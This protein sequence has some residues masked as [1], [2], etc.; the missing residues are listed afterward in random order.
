M[1][2]SNVMKGIGNVAGSLL[3]IGA[4]LFGQAKAAEQSAKNVQDTIAHQKEM[5]QYAYGKDLEMWERQN[6]YNEPSQQ[7]ARL[8]EAGLNPNL[9][10]GGGSVNNTSS[11]MP[12]YQQVK[13]DYSGRRNPLEALATMGMYQDLKL[14][15][16]QVDNVRAQREGQDIKNGITLLNKRMET[17]RTNYFLKD[18]GWYKEPWGYT[19]D[20]KK[21]AGRSSR[22]GSKY[23]HFL[24]SQFDALILQNHLK[25]QSYQ[26]SRENTGN[27]SIDKQLKMFELDMWNSLGK[28]GK[29]AKYALPFLKWMSGR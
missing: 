11:T 5:A 25:R 21:T 26:L 19:G 9:V 18:R 14:K 29:Y 12:K 13:P 3:G 4:P 2:F 15:Q 24:D 1:S 23:M 28:E 22:M 27:K 10:F 16:A 7:M 20:G 6:L 8:K 17:A